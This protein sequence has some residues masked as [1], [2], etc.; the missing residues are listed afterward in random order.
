M[1]DKINSGTK[2]GLGVDRDMTISIELI[3]EM[4]K[5]TNCSYQEAKELLEKH[6]GDIVEA[7]IEFEKKQGI[8]TNNKFKF[9]AKSSHQE[10]AKKVF[11]KSTKTRF[12]IEKDG[13][14]I[15]NISLLVL[16]IALLVTIPLFWLYLVLF[17]ALYL[18]GYKIRIRK[19]EGK[20]VNIN[21]IVDEI[22]NKVRNT[23]DKAQEKNPDVQESV[24]KNEESKDQ[25]Y[26]EITVE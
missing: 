21:E 25:K 16:I 10:K 3:D 14:T 11:H 2:K 17:V 20:D 19:E 1:R 9:K 12:I 26:N 15:L 5:R 24:V 13:N 23:T 7:I 18:L 22:S 8:N 6:Q 4:R